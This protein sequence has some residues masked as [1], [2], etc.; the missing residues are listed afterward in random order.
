MLAIDCITVG[1]FA[2]NCYLVRGSTCAAVLIDPGAEAGT[3]LEALEHH[4]LKTTAYLIT[5]GHTDHVSA[6][7]DLYARHSA[8]Y[9]MSELDYRWAFTSANQLLPYYP[10]PRQPPIPPIFLEDRQTW[11]PVP[12]L[13]FRILATPG[14]SPGGIC[15]YLEAEGVI[16]TGDTLFHD[17]VGRT[18]MP[19]GNQVLL[20]QSL[21]TLA[22]LPPDTRIYPG[23]GPSTTLAEELRTNPYLAII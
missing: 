3:I 16:F 14:H 11:N 10:V 19:G 7:A 20:E 18:D 4:R 13:S 2:V 12:E 17:T 5:H 6:L 22:Q 1:T 9:A 8:P 23:H 21:K 15:A